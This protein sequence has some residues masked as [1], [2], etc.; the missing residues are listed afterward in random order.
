MRRREGEEEE[1]GMMMMIRR[2]GPRQRN[3]GGRILRPH[4]GPR[5][6]VGCVGLRGVPL[7]AEGDNGR[8]PARK[9][10]EGR[11]NNCSEAAGVKVERGS[12]L[13]RPLPM[14]EC[15]VERAG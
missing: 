14:T 10:T 5:G 9:E 7:Q 6:A 8:G 13:T 3:K 15:D 2:R 12:L 11:M 1:G 4:I